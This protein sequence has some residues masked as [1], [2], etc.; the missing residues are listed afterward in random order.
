MPYLIDTD[1][2]IDLTRNRQGAVEYVDG[3]GDDWS[4]SAISG[5]ELIVGAKNHR[6]VHEIDRLLAS[7][8]IRHIS[9]LVEHRAYEILRT[10][11]CARPSMI[12]YTA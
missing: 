6:E 5:L 1:I 9:S 4:I 11:S 12:R 7:Y 3:L 10:A 8:E 2:L